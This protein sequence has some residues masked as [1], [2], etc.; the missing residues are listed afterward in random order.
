MTAQLQTLIICVLPSFRIIIYGIIMT[1]EFHGV[2][3][4]NRIRKDLA[5]FRHDA[6]ISGR[7]QHISFQ[8]RKTHNTENDGKEDQPAQR[9]FP[10]VCD[11]I[12]AGF[13][14][15]YIFQVLNLADR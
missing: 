1:A 15:L 11:K 9:R 2:F 12:S 7:S 4:Y 13:Y 6:K 5:P 14:R 3:R 8:L 10:S